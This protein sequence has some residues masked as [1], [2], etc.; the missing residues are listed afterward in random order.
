LVKLLLDV[1]DGHFGWSQYARLGWYFASPPQ[2]RNRGRAQKF[3]KHLTNNYTS[4]MAIP[5]ETEEG[6]PSD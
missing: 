4:F 6:N 2:L 5:H 3:F 1:V